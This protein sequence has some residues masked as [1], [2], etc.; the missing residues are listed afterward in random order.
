MGRGFS[1]VDTPPFFGDGLP[2][3]LVST[4]WCYR[5]KTSVG[6]RSPEL[7]RYTFWLETILVEALPE[8]SLCMTSVEFRHEPAGLEDREVDRLHADGSYLHSVWTLYG[9]ATIYRD[10]RIEKP[11]PNGQTLLMTAIESCRKP[12]ARAL[13]C[14][15]VRS[16]TGAGG[17]RLLVRPPWNSRRRRSVHRRAAGASI[18]RATMS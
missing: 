1:L 17:D 11:V 6:G 5:S 9:P 13:P 4:G 18:E 7:A 8:E 12:F 10:G 15:G 16:K 14:T 2:S 3:V